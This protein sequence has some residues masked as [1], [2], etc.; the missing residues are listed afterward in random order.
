MSLS[1]NENIQ[2]IPSPKL[3]SNYS[4]PISIHVILFYFLNLNNRQTQWKMII[5]RVKLCFYQN[6]RLAAGGIHIT[7][8]SMASMSANGYK[9][10]FHEYLKMNKWKQALIL[11]AHGLFFF[12]VVNDSTTASLNYATQFLVGRRFIT[13]HLK[14]RRVLVSHHIWNYLCQSSCSHT[15]KPM[16]GICHFITC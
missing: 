2:P 3:V 8:E 15:R 10:G 16:C 1:R 12:L 9:L 7:F 6:K 11:L 14:W 5:I 4:Y 13:S